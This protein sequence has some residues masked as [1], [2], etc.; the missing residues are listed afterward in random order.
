MTWKKVK[1]EDICTIKGRI[2]YRGYAKKDLV[3][4]GFG[5]IS[6]SPSNIISNKLDYN[7]TT[8]ISWIK[9][10]ESPEIIVKKGDVIFCKTASIGK[11]ALVDDLPEK[12]TLNPQMVVL[13]NIKCNNKFLFYSMMNKSYLKQIKEI[14]GGAAIPTLSQK[15][16][17]ST[18]IYL[19]SIS[20]QLK[21]V[22]EIENLFKKINLALKIII[23]KESQINQLKIY[24]TILFMNWI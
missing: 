18:F 3:K 4:K 22:S 20:I 23:Q 10:E 21:I 6:L 7:K 15:D 11:M 13:K 17:A 8:Y 2:G 5:A 16:L 12:A 1:L 14:T 9:Y 19:P 24:L